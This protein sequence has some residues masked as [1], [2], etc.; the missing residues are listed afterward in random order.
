[1]Q[2]DTRAPAPRALDE[3][4]MIP[5]APSARSTPRPAPST[6]LRSLVTLAA[7]GLAALGAAGCADESE[8]GMP[9]YPGL[10]DMGPA[11]MVEDLPDPVEKD[12]PDISGQDTLRVLLV[13]NSTSYFIYRGE[14]MGFEFRALRRF[15]SDHDMALRVVPVA[16]R[17][18]LFHR[19]NEGEGD[20]AGARI[21]PEA[22]YRDEVLLTEPLYWTRPTVV[23]RAGPA[24]ETVLPAVVDSFLDPEDMERVRLDRMARLDS[25]APADTAGTGT[26]VSMGPAPP[27]L[28]R[29]PEELAGE[30]V[31][32]PG[33]SEYVRRVAEI[34]D[35]ER[36]H[37][38]I[39]EVDSARSSE[40][41][42]REVARGAI[43]Y[44]VAPTNV[45]DLREPYFDNVVTEPVVGASHAVV[46]A[47]R[48]TS[49][50]LRRRLDDWIGEAH[51]TGY[52]DELYED[53]FVDRESYVER[54]ASRYLTTE[55]GR[56]SEFD[57]L[58]FEHARRLDW[59]WRLLASQ[60]FQESR[61]DPRA[62]SWAGARGILQLMP[63]TAR[64]MGVGN[65]FDPEQNLEGAV[66]YLQWLE[67]RWAGE[68]QD[69]D[70]RL[71]FVLGSYN[72]GFGHVEDAQRM[73]RKYGDDPT[74]WEDVAFWL[75]QLSQRRW[76]SDPVVR[77]G[78]VRGVE[79]VTYVALILERFDHYRQFVA[80]VPVDVAGGPD[81]V[82]D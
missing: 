44:T 61:F 56:L 39:I 63:G 57:A 71:K 78:Y 69:P 47:V 70:Q 22:V 20:I 5:E 58:L 27:R 34:Y 26:A 31:Y 43:E 15:A 3:V 81:R 49:P 24:E 53:Y 10:E 67:E 82:G 76:Y 75:L 64:D 36:G 13:N 40:P 37:L 23:Q 19:L 12:W 7:V 21:V 9:A 1:M 60:A 45:A 28:I 11:R 38:R 68:V 51:G 62:V 18:E 46:W 17:T 48:T 4:R 41:L 29:S 66:R 42:M 25:A 2:S 79:P 6:P 33:G 77:Y 35:E 74:A 50:D 59:D 16:N 14:A 72:A 52:V 8:G 65:V 32:L 80:E 30:R 73:A 54:V 55:T